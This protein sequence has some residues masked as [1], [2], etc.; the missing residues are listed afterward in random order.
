[1]VLYAI[2]FLYDKLRKVGTEMC[3]F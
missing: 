1:V 2:W 3:G